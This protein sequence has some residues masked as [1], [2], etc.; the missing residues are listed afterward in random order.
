MGFSV[1]TWAGLLG[2]WGMGTSAD[3]TLYKYY[4]AEALVAGLAL[5]GTCLEALNTTVKCNETAI[6]LLREGADIH[7]WNTGDAQSLCS[8]DCV[9]GLSAWESRVD[10]VCGEE[11]TIQ[12]GIVV[13]ARA[14]PLTFTYNAGLVCTRDAA[15]SWCF[16]ESQTWRGS[17]YIRWEPTMCF[18]DGDDNS[19]VAPQCSDPEFDLNEVNSNMAAIKNLYDKE[20]YCSDC[21]LQLYRKRLLNPW[22]SVN[23]FTDYLIDEFD[24]LQINCS[25]TL[26]YRTS[27]ST[28]YIGDATSTTTTGKTVTYPS[29]TAT[30]TCMGQMVEPI[31]NWLICND[32]SDTYQISTG[33]ARVATGDMDCFF[34]R[35][36]CVPFPC[37]LDTVWDEPSCDELAERYSNSTYTVTTIQFLSWNKN[38]QGSCS[39]IAPGQRVCKGAPGGTSPKPNATIIAPGATGTPTYYEAVKPAHPTQSG[40]I[41]ECGAFYLV[42]AGDDCFTVT[43]RFGLGTGKLWEYNT[44][45]DAA[46]TNLWLGYDA[47]VAPVTPPRPSTDGTCPRGVTCA[48]TTF[49]EC[50]SQFGFCGSGP[51]YC[52]GGGGGPPET[53]D[54]TCGLDYGD[55][56]C[57]PVFG[58]CCSIYGYCGSGS[59]FCGPGNCYSG[60]CDPD[61]GG[62]STNGECGP[63][64]AGNKICT[65]TQFGACCSV[66]GYCGNEDDYCA[67]SNCHSGVCTD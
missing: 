5:S 15:S 2:I 31:E 64:K 49:G 47:C 57:T 62:P 42:A 52:G 39:G 16:V 45:L 50:C 9:N 6:N 27:A 12:N 46:C 14:L 10:S 24:D 41:S 38:I 1:L 65:G 29:T 30:P 48:G 37:E 63:T 28:L 21:F 60:D 66:H 32:L 51:E 22:L 20:L 61:E 13:K 40:T 33:D 59:D 35:P 4:D 8:A 55:T 25:T 7:Y 3:F 23:N 67:G 54:G 34:D 58:A 53:A 56:V 19:T 26:P 36:V 44:Y 11:T 43:Q 18:S 17:D